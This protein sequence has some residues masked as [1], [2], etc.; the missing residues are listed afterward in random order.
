MTCIW[1]VSPWRQ[2]NTGPGRLLLTVM[3]GRIRPVKLTLDWPIRS[4][5]GVVCR[6][7]SGNSGLAASTGRR[8]KPVP[9][10]TPPN[11]KPFQEATPVNASLGRE[12]NSVHRDSHVR[13][14][15]DGTIASK[16]NTEEVR[17]GDRKHP[18]GTQAMGGRMGRSGAGSPWL[19]S[20]PASGG[21]RSS[22]TTGRMRN[23]TGRALLCCKQ[24]Q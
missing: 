14:F 7:S 6:C 9:A 18:S 15:G 22:N 16:G 1:T 5:R 13:R 21:I 4:S 10:T 20:I 3:A 17:Y 19:V 11:A 8:H 12:G 23:V 24:S 2:R